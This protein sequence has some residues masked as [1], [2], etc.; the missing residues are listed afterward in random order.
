LA[1]EDKRDMK[2]YRAKETLIMSELS[3]YRRKHPYFNRILKDEVIGDFENTNRMLVKE[4][5]V[6]RG[7]PDYALGFFEF[8][9]TT[10]DPSI[11]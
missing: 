4:T 3:T 2:L 11:P 1:E 10:D 8:I 6:D 7:M 9:G 5:Q